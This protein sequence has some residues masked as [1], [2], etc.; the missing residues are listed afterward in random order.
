MRYGVEALVGHTS[1]PM[2]LLLLIIQITSARFIRSTPAL[3][4]D[5]HT[6]NTG[7]LIISVPALSKLFVI[8][9]LPAM[10]KHQ[11]YRHQIYK[12]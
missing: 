9:G 11:N 4:I 12:I 3:T 8:T 7:H 2:L 5:L 1:L 6:L 10:D